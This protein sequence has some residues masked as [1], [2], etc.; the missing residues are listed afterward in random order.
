MNF[1]FVEKSTLGKGKK[2]IDCLIEKNKFQVDRLR[3][4]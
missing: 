4:V 2:L 3:L 1:F